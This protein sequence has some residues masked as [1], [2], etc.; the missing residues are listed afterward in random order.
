[1]RRLSCFNLLLILLTSAAIAQR[2]PAQK[3][4]PAKQQAEPVVIKLNVSVMDRNKRPVTDL[5]AD[6]FTVFEDDVLQKVTSL[7]P[8]SGPLK[9]DLLIDRSGSMRSE[10]SNVVGA[11]QL[12]V[13]NM[14]SD[15]ECQIIPFVSSDNITLSQGFTSNK[16]LLRRALSQLFVEGGA[17]AVIDALYVAT[18]TLADQSTQVD[19]STRRAIVVISDGEDSKSFY[20]RDQLLK[21]VEDLGVPI[22]FVQLGARDDYDKAE[23]AKKLVER[24]A[25]ISGGAAY[26]VDKKFDYSQAVAAIDLEL[27]PQYVVTYTSTN[28]ALNGKA[29]KIRVEVNGAAGNESFSVV[30]RPTVTVPKKF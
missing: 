14:Q 1:M 22:F 15:D 11:A 20:K 29:R 19:P 3:D 6:R 12:L 2:G 5:T 13:D 30:V 9:F 18:K 10:F 28:S 17:S 27:R 16:M 7:Q 24:I 4:Q 26:S 23:K 25:L 21:V 8:K